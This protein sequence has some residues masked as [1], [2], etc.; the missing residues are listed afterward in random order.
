MT[1]E[2]KDA[3]DILELSNW[4]TIWI[5]EWKI[6]DYDIKVKYKDDNWTWHWRQPKHIHWIVDWMLKREHNIDK[7][8]E[9]V[10]FFQKLWDENSPEEATK[11][12]KSLYDKESN[13]NEL[14]L[15]LLEDI[16]EFEELNSDWYYHV[17]FL[18]FSWYLLLLQ[19][20]T[21]RADAYMFQRMFSALGKE[22]SDLYK[23]ITDAT[24]NYSQK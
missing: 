11:I 6:S 15:N 24:S 7:I 14:F 9:L 1:R 2:L 8:R 5:I 12:L 4:I 13:L 10:L 21:N 17:D 18:I 3:I 16:K 23:I 19:E 20:K 22:Y